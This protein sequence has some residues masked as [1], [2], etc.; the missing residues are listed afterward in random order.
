MV[1]RGPIIFLKLAEGKEGEIDGVITTTGSNSRSLRNPSDTLNLTRI[2]ELY[3]S[4]YRL[5]P[6]K[7]FCNVQIATM[8]D[9]PDIDLDD[10]Q[11]KIEWESNYYKD[12]HLPSR[13]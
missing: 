3:P 12:T 10:P 4:K 11:Q 6:R 9:K 8:L 5:S 2:S 1:A 13:E 7:S